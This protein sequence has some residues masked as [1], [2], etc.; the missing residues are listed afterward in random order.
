[1]LALVT[2]ATG[3]AGGRLVEK[4]VEKGA[5]VRVIVRDKNRLN[6]KSGTPVEILEGDICDLK[7]VQRAVKGVNKIFH[8]AA[9]YRTAGVADSVYQEV[10]VT[11]TGYLLEAAVDNGVERFVH[12]STIGIHGDIEKPP[13]NEDYR[14]KPGDIYQQTKLEGE[15][16]ALK[17]YQDTRLGVTV[18][19]PC[20]IYGPG[21]LRL[22]KLFKLAARNPMLLLGN[23]KI[24]YHMVHGEDLADGFIL[25][26]EKEKAIG[27]SFIIGSPEVFSVTEL[28]VMISKIMG[29]SSHKI[30]KLPIKPFQVL[31]SITEKLCIPFG[32]EPPIY[33]RRV[34]FFANNR[35]FDT[36]K[37]EKLLGFKCRYTTEQGLIQTYEWFKKNNLL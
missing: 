30:L 3:F 2:G 11:A 10:H 29:K 26:S 15:H 37:A 13:A 24:K 17:F 32:I 14:F 4:L 16:L 25:A 7:L 22:L 5:D 33:R 36:S 27:E 21:D 18:I 12:T 8:L 6:L 20:A 23:G 19:R 9:C 35:E 34:D 1:M 31:G 28:L